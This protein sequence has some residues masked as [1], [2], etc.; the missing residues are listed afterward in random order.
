MVS[1]FQPKFTV[2][3]Y[4]KFL[5]WLLQNRSSK[6][7]E[8]SISRILPTFIRQMFCHIF[9]YFNNAQ[10]FSIYSMDGEALAFE[11]VKRVSTGVA[12]HYPIPNPTLS[13]TFQCYTKNCNFPY[14]FSSYRMDDA[15]L[16]WN[17]KTCICWVR[18]LQNAHYIPAPFVSKVTTISFV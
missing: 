17:S 15:D 12:S 1:I 3:Y 11:I 10:F 2:W 5:F 14:F 7:S 16:I 4:T 8:R 13:H 9:S 18:L 6:L